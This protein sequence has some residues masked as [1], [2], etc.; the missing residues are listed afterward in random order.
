[1]EFFIDETCLIQR[2]MKLLENVLRSKDSTVVPISS[3]IF[4]LFSPGINGIAVFKSIE[5]LYITAN[6]RLP[7]DFQIIFPSI[8][9]ASEEPPTR[10]L[11]K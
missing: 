5:K 2:V 9:F 3:M 6:T 8:V 1:M 4:E 11:S 7:I 10:K